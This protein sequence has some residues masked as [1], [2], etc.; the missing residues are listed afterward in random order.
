LKQ[1]AKKICG[2]DKKY[3]DRFYSYE[4]CLKLLDLVVHKANVE[5]S[6][7]DV[8]FSVKHFKES[9]EHYCSALVGST[10]DIGLAHSW[11]QCYQSSISRGQSIIIDSFGMDVRQAVLKTVSDEREVLHMAIAIS[12]WNAKDVG[13]FKKIY[14]LSFGD[15]AVMRA[16]PSGRV[17]P[18]LNLS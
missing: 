2:D 12:K 4:N 13:A 16:T 10:N 9:F 15:E 5:W 7:Y 11:F 17:A 18:S 1:L 8:E 14:E 3:Y 6:R